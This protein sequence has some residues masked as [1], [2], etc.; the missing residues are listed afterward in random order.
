MGRNEITR[1]FFSK[2]PKGSEVLDVNKDGKV[3]EA[4]AAELARRAKK[5]APEKCVIP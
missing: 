3:D 1:T 2:K 5:C 4:D